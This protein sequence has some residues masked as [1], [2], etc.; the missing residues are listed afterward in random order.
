MTT[1]AYKR[2]VL[3]YPLALLLAQQIKALLSLPVDAIGTALDLL[4]FC[5]PRWLCTAYLA[6]PIAVPTS[7]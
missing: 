2:I 7:H 3:L 1:M 6:L 4:L 5:R